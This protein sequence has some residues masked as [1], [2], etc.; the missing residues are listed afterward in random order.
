MLEAIGL[1]LSDRG[2]YLEQCSNLE[3][4]ETVCS[5]NSVFFE[6]YREYIF[7]KKIYLSNQTLNEGIWMSHTSE[8]S[9]NKCWTY[10]N[11]Y[12]NV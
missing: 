4:L 5:K 8:S 7:W 3:L 1:I 12:K 6:E 11:I 2:I 9:V 10:R